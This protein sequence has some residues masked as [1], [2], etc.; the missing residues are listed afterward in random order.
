MGWYTSW[1][2][3]T[4][5]Y[6]RDCSIGGFMHSCVRYR[7]EDALASTQF[8]GEHAVECPIVSTFGEPLLRRTLNREDVKLDSCRWWAL[9]GLVLLHRITVCLLRRVGPSCIVAHHHVFH[10]PS[11][12]YWKP[13]KS[14]RIAEILFRF[15]WVGPHRHRHQARG[16]IKSLNFNQFD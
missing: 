10:T 1:K 4:L 6:C 5:P 11:R 9:W 14:L 12:P 8:T 2:P 15:Q 16:N 13:C 7:R 3:L